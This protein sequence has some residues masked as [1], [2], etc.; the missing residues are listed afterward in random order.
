MDVANVQLDNVYIYAPRYPARFL[1]QIPHSK[2][3]ECNHSQAKTFYSLYPKDRS[4]KAVA[5]Q[6]SAVKTLKKGNDILNKLGV[7][8]WMSSGTCLG[9]I[10]RIPFL[11]K[12]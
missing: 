9:N 12:Y 1:I 8:F 11:D 10:I 2:F 5:F 7:R 6:K 4:K 3:L